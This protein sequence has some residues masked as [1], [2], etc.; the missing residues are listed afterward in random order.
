MYHKLI[1]I[2]NFCIGNLLFFGFLFLI[3]Y[4]SV[5]SYIWVFAVLFAFFL[6]YA[7]KT[8]RTLHYEIIG[9]YKVFKSKKPH[10][11][12]ENISELSA[13]GELWEIKNL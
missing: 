6:S 11:I 7:L 10:V 3:F 8:L 2:L 1:Y 9:I 13:H 4:I 5:I 12:I